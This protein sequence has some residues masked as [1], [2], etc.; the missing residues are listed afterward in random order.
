MPSE[1]HWDDVSLRA[2]TVRLDED[3]I[4]LIQAD[5]DRL[6]VS[7]SHYVGAAGLARATIAWAHNQPDVVPSRMQELYATA[8][9]L[10]RDTE[11]P[12]LDG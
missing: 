12:W 6:G 1:E 4:A 9:Q 2:I 3:E 11:P 10:I 7:L 8:Q 5:A